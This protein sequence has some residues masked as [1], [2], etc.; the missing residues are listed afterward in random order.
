MRL[1]I[2]E[3]NAK[4][5]RFFLENYGTDNLY[6][7]F[8]ESYTKALNN[9]EKQKKYNR[10][11]RQRPEVKEKNRQRSRQNWLKKKNKSIKQ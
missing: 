5:I 7:I 3:S 6:K 4:K 2:T 11:Y 10:E 8:N 9:K 1:E